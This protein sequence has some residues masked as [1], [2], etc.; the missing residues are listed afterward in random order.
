[1]TLETASTDTGALLHEQ[2]R[3]LARQVRRSPHAVLIVASAIVYGVYPY[4]PLA[5]AFAWLMFVTMSVLSRWAYA[6]YVLR[7]A[8]IVNSRHVMRRL[9][10]FAFINGTAVGVS[11]PLFF[12]ALPDASRAIVAMVLVGLSAGGIAT[13]AAYRP[14]FAAYILPALLPLAYS[15]IMAG[16]ARH[17][18]IGALVLLFIFILFTFVRENHHLLSQSFS[19]RFE[20]EHLVQAL[21][22]KQTELQMAKEQAEEAGRAKA[23]ILAAAS[24]DLRQPLHAL[25]LYSAV[26]ARNPTQETLTVVSQHID[27]SVRALSALLNALL[28]VSRLDAGVFQ[29]EQCSFDVATILQRVINDYLELARQKGLA[30]HLHSVPATVFSDPIV[31]ERITRNLIDN[32]IKYTDHG[33][34]VVTI[35]QV[36]N[37]ARIDVRDSGKGI[38]QDEQQRV[39]EEFYQLDNPGR[40]REQGLGL[41]LSIVKRLTELIGCTISVI[42]SPGR[43]SCFSLTLPLDRRAAIDPP[44]EIQAL[45][46][47]ALTGSNMRILLI[48]DESAIRHG[49]SLLLESWGAIPF[50][51][52]DMQNAQDILLA[53]NGNID[54]IVAD[55]RLQNGADGLQVVVALR[56]QWG[57]IPVLLASGETDPSK[58]K[59][60]AASGFP[61]LHKPISPETLHQNI[62]DLL[63]PAHNKN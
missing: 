20:R 42:S 3:L 15:W 6:G 61:L 38:P 28:D 59:G 47:G 32:A 27:L 43:G 17:I 57:P 29:I 34:V 16:G 23:R 31:V 30:F 7:E 13:S 1:M 39:F 60:V 11:A 41:G 63:G 26:L 35:R 48:D 37:R 44:E 58:L 50:S 54:L 24:H 33:S 4:V 56:K 8:N 52:A 9:V 36:G 5:L 22:Q 51:A 25:S 53:E 55:L 49:M 21:E 10:L 12:A 2:V 14:A 40:D 45:G 19:I 46:D 18:M 62:I